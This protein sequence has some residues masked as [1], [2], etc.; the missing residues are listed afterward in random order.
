MPLYL[1]PHVITPL[2]NHARRGDLWIVPEPVSYVDSWHLQHRLASERARNARSDCL[3]LL[4]HRPVYTMGRTTKPWHLGE[5]ETRL[6]ATGAEVHHV[7]RGGSITYHGPG[8][9]VGYPILRLADHCSGPR[10]Y[11][12]L[13]ED[14]LIRT[15]RRWDIAAQRRDGKR[16]VWVRTKEDRKIASIGVR[17]DRGITLHGLAL[18]VTVE[19]SPF[20]RIIPCG[21]PDCR[22]TSMVEILGAPID[23]SSVAATL[24]ESWSSVFAMDWARIV[25]DPITEANPCPDVTCLS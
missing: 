22:V 9:L 23:V 4:E 16:G 13:L 2:E 12:S 24:I 25:T 21:I 14:V 11:V 17:V 1:A 3:L 19:L 20:L 7:N 5:D 10:E 15:L 18:N 8:Q 6:R